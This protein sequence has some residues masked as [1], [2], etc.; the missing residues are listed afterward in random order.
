MNADGMI[1]NLTDNSVSLTLNNV[2]QT[3]DETTNDDLPILIANSA[4]GGTAGTKYTSGVKINPFSNKVTATTFVGALDGNANTASAFNG[5]TTVAI[6]GGASGTS[7]S[8]TK[9]W[10]T[11]VDLNAKL[12]C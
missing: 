10:S 2:S 4:T 11:A 8:S 6:T 5:G 3:K 9:G 7:S 1:S 12:V